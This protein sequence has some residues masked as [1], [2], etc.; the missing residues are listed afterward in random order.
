MKLRYARGFSMVEILVVVAI[1]SLLAALTSK[2][3]G[4]YLANSKVRGVTE[5][6]QQALVLGRSEAIK[7]NDTVRVSIGANGGWLIQ[8]YNPSTSAIM[9]I[10][11]KN[12]NPQSKA[13]VAGVNNTIRF[14]G[15]GRADLATLWD[16]TSSNVGLVCG[17]D[18]TCLRIEL[19]RLGKIRVCNPNSGNTVLKC[20]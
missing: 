9:T 10:T 13:I 16:I 8:G 18:I 4:T 14:N 11:E 7:R 17:T 2:G 20:G 12:N 19:T 15:N 1:I 6:V 5:D 3:M